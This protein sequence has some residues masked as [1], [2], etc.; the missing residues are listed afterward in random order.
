MLME[1]K[2]ADADLRRE[3]DDIILDYV[4]FAALG[5][6]LEDHENQLDEENNAK[7]KG[8]PSILLRLV[9]CKL[10]IRYSWLEQALT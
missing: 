8:K 4:V 5:H 10:V 9:D 7:P 1:S 2:C 6:V 3:V